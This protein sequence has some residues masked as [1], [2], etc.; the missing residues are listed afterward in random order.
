M[1]EENKNA[2]PTEEYNDDGSKNPDFVTPKDESEDAV[3]GIE[4][5]GEEGED[6]KK[7]GEGEED[8]DDTIDPVKPP[9][10]PTRKFNAQHII[11]R[12]NA[13]IEKLESKLKDGEESGVDLEADEEEDSN[14]TEQARKAID[15]TVQKAMAPVLTK[16][17]SEADEKEMQNLL[18]S[19]P[20]SKKYLNHIKA[21][22]THDAYKYV[23]PAVIYHHLAFNSALLQ[24]AKKKMI[25]DK[26]AR[27][28]K[29]GGRTIVKD[30]PSGNLPSPDDITNMSEEDFEKMENDARQGKFI[31][32]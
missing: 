15:T 21:Y 7:D 16:L 4:N 20:E 32:K 24:G 8:F 27:Q 11:A 31:K 10:I 22:M 23:A 26:E 6:G 1:A 19:E 12:K 18:S 17:A 14:L 30:E 9:E 2:A 29:S 3:A 5:K 28:N 25:A 13:K